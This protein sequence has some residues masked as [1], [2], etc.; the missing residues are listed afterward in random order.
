MSQ[1]YM[2]LRKIRSNGNDNND[3]T[4]S[5]SLEKVKEYAIARSNIPDDM[6]KLFVAVCEIEIKPVKKFRLFLITKRLL[7]LV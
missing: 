7:S 1:I 2:F 5:W 3:S 4:H 6:D